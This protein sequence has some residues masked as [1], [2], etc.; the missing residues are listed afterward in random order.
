MMERRLQSAS[1]IREVRSLL[2]KEIYRED[3][4]AAKRRK[5]RESFGGRGQIF[6][7]IGRDGALTLVGISVSSVSWFPRLKRFSRKKAQRTQKAEEG[8]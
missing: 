5:G 7:E 6:N 4:E 1:L 8:F 2:G 3:T